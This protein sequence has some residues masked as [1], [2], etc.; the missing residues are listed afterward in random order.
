MATGLGK[1]KGASINH[2]AKLIYDY[3][4]FNLLTTCEY[5]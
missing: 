5:A 3:A 4:R 2:R 1:Q